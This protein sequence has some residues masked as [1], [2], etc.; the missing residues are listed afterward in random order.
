MAQKLRNVDIV[1]GGDSHTLLGD[2]TFQRFGFTPN[3]DYPY[4]TRTSDNKMVCV[5]QAWHY[6]QLIGELDVD[7]DANG[8]VSRCGGQPIL[9]IGDKFVFRYNNTLRKELKGDDHKLILDQLLREDEVRVT[10]DDPAV[11]AAIAKYNDVKAEL[12][13][14]IIGSNADDLCLDGFPGAHWSN[15]CLRQATYK[16]GSDIT[17]LVAKAF[18]TVTKGADIGLQNAGGVRMDLPSGEVSIASAQT[19]LP[20]GNVLMTF[21]MTGADLKT[22]IEDALSYPLDEG[23]S[24]GAFPYAFGMRYTLD[25]SM[26]YGN[27]VSNVEINK[28]G[29]GSWVPLDDTAYYTIVTNNYIGGGKDGYAMFGTYYTAG[30]YVNTFLEYMQAFVDFVRAEGTLTR[31]PDEFYSTQ[32]FINRNGCDHSLS[33]TC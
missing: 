1:V 31:Q 28:R 24:A 22:V 33:D 25:L 11:A 7:F 30:K 6:S 12:E 21:N 5:V 10:A 15:L 16:H 18:M 14:Q 26:G 32:R 8:E 2:S 13:Q 23:G 27:R 29:A 4:V 17:T 19:L 3:G 9:P 20:F